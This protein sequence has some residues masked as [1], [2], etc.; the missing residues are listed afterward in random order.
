[1]NPLHAVVMDDASLPR[2]RPSQQ[3]DASPLLEL[4]ISGWMAVTLL[5]ACV[6]PA[7]ER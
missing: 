4:L 2:W 7:S 3:A 5:P 1:M 6:G